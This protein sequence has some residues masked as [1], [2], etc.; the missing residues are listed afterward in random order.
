M[1]RWKCCSPSVGV[2]SSFLSQW[3]LNSTFRNVLLEIIAAQGA[4]L[5]FF[6][7][8]SSSS[9]LHD[10]WRLVACSPW[11]IESLLPHAVTSL[12]MHLWTSLHLHPALLLPRTL[13]SSSSEVSAKTRTNQRMSSEHLLP[14]I[15][16]SPWLSI[17]FHFLIYGLCFSFIYP[18]HV[19]SYSFNI[20]SPYHFRHLKISLSTCVFVNRHSNQWLKY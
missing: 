3:D 5:L 2:F 20:C 16:P 9:P 4:G 12:Y 7:G 18:S 10:V 11:V 17:C 19:P 14:H 6:L 13:T 1:V 15:C 8:L